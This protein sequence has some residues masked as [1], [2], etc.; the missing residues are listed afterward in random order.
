M[1]VE[2]WWN[3]AYR[4]KPKNSKGKKPVPVPL[5]HNSY[6]HWLRLEPRPTQYAASEWHNHSNYE[7]KRIKKLVWAYFQVPFVSTDCGKPLEAYQEKWLPSKDRN[8]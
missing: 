3:D 2:H 8:P 4:R 6:M 7:L 5:C 1:I